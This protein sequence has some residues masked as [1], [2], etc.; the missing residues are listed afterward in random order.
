MK[1]R[2]HRHACLLDGVW[3]VEW[4]GEKTPELIRVQGGMWELR[5]RGSVPCFFLTSGVGRPKEPTAGVRMDFF[6]CGC[7]RCGRWCD[8]F[9][10]WCFFGSFFLSVCSGNHWEM[11][12]FLLRFHC[13]NGGDGQKV[14]AHHSRSTDSKLESLKKTSRRPTNIQNK[15]LTLEPTKQKR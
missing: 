9:F 4:G 7:W 8:F 1:L 3:R 11:H 6:G 15:N 2:S 12:S 10:V 5:C 13:W 14:A